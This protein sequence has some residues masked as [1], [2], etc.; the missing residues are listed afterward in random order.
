MLSNMS[1]HCQMISVI[2]LMYFRDLGCIVIRDFCFM[3]LQVVVEHRLP[4]LLPMRRELISF[5][6]SSWL[7]SEDLIHNSSSSHS[8]KLA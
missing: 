8:S 7:G 4:K 1:Q 2:G 3:G 6:L 5:I